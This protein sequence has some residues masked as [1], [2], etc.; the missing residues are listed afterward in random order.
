MRN[1]FIFISLSF[2]HSGNRCKLA[3]ELF[4]YV[5]I[6]VKSSIE[7]SIGLQ[8]PKMLIDDRTQKGSLAAPIGEPFLIPFTPFLVPGRTIL[9]LW[10][11]F[12]MELKMCLLGS[13]RFLPGRD[14]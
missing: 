1:I 12:Y 6:P 14:R 11:G 13:K 10:K 9:G 4:V 2:S 7:P 8:K 3:W 5:V